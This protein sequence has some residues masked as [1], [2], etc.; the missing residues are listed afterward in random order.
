MI[1][2]MV[3]FSFDCVLR[4][5][6]AATIIDLVMVS[7]WSSVFFGGVID[8]RIW[9]VHQLVVAEYPRKKRRKTIQIQNT[10]SQI[11]PPTPPTRES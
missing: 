5:S 2:S 7:V 10:K 11:Q 4:S 3:H 8:R 9:H 1:G 6:S